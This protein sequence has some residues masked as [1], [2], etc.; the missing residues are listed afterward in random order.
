MCA[1]RIV[2]QKPVRNSMNMP[3]VRKQY[4]TL[5]RSRISTGEIIDGERERG[6]ERKREGECPW[7]SLIVTCSEQNRYTVYMIYN[8][9]FYL[10]EKKSIDVLVCVK[11]NQ[12][13]KKCSSYS[14]KYYIKL[15]KIYYHN[16]IY[17]IK[18][19]WCIQSKYI[20]WFIYYLSLKCAKMYA[21]YI[22]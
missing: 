18:Y 8:I 3:A 2:E 19:I 15:Y 6:G 1:V 14:L 9:Y 12:T 17:N 7:I 21:V 11:W 13:H 20:Q 22:K 16:C 5:I 10:E 4:S